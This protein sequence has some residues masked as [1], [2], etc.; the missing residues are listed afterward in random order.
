VVRT[1][2]AFDRVFIAPA[3]L[4]WQWRRGEA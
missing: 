1:V 2:P 4:Y 3:Y